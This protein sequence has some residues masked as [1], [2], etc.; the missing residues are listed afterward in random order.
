MQWNV[1]AISAKKEELK[2]FVKKNDID[3]MFLQETKM[4]PGDA[5]PKIPGY[6]FTRR[7]RIQPKGKGKNRGGGLLIGTKNTIPFKSINRDI[8]ETGDHYTEF[9]TI[10]LP[11]EN[12]NPLSLTNVYVPPISTDK[13]DNRWRKQEEAKISLKNW[14]HGDN[15]IIL[16]DINAHSPKWEVNCNNNTSDRRGKKFDEWLDQTRMVPLNTGD[17]TL[18]R[19]SGRG[20]PGSR[21]QSSPDITFAS[22]ALLDK[23]EW[24][25]INDLGSDHLP[26]IITYDTSLPKVNT[27]SVYKWKLEDADWRAF[28]SEVERNLPKIYPTC[29]VN[30]LEKKFSKIVIN[31]ANRCVGTKKIRPDAKCWFSK[32][33]KEGIRERNKL[34]EN[35]GRNRKEWCTKGAEV[36]KLIR[37]EREAKWRDY[38]EGLERTTDPRKVWRTIRAMDGRSQPQKKNEVLEVDGIDYVDDRDKAEQFAKT[39]RNFSRLPVRRSDRALRK[40][41][42]ELNKQKPGDAR[43]H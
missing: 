24:K 34:R 32:N 11:T 4:I 10:E 42:R 1:D 17:Y 18:T 16:G 40:K 25:T 28:T 41:N 43:C 38:V 22:P 13:G 19:K 5:D 36:A 12:Q 14:P 26:I 29:G 31:A 35:F 33:V 20:A 37:D 3:L 6:T 23:L 27:K 8:R 2:G 15:N 7:D 30:K 21:L 39:Y 9:Q